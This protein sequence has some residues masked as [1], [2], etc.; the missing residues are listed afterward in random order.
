MPTGPAAR[1]ADNVAHPLPPVLG[2]GPGSL[3]VLIGSMPAWRGVGAAAAAAIQAAKATSDA[4]IKTAEAATL[5][6]S[7]TPGAPAAK[8]AEET[9]KA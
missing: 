7:G 6:A 9:A 2:V 8:V 3:T 1:V 5:A 4:A